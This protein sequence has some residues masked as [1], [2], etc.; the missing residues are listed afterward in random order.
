METSSPMVDAI[1]QHL[2]GDVTVL[3]AVDMTTL[4][5]APTKLLQVAKTLRDHDAFSFSSLVDVCGV[6]YMTYGQTDWRTDADVTSGFSRGTSR[7]PIQTAPAWNGARFY[8]VYHLLSTELNH[9]LRIKV[10]CDSEAVVPSLCDIWPAANWYEREVFDLFGIR[11]KGHP[12]LRSLLTD[13]GFQGHPFRK[14]FPLIGEVEMRYD[15]AQA[16]CV[17]EPTSI[18]ERVTV[19]R[20]IRVDNRYAPDATAADEGQ[21]K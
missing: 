16:R 12:D 2:T 7:A 4:E 9:R 18:V 14:D 3:D 15:A 11:F 19:P 6:D 20:V 13:Y 8:V 1:R 5:V 10:P 21:S 17:Y